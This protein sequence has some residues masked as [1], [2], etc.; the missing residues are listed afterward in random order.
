MTTGPSKSA[1]KEI[2]DALGED[3]EQVVG[4]LGDNSHGPVEA[5]STGCYQLDEATGIGGV[6]RGR[7]VEI[8][9]PKVRASQPS[10]TTSSLSARP[11]AGLLGS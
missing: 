7:I 10:S 9:G 6:P 3:G 1:L 4:F 5:I 8:Y 2:N 11:T